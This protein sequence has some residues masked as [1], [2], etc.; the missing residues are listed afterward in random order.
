M[1]RIA[2]G[3]PINLINKCISTLTWKPGKT[4]YLYWAV[5][6]PDVFSSCELSVW[7]K[8]LIDGKGKENGFWK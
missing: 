7:N 5:M 1:L 6:K 4:K 3:S 2:R 8:N